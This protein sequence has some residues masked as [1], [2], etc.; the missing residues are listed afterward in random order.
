M[1]RK[2]G[3]EK[4]N[5]FVNIS[6]LI[7]V[8]SIWLV[9]RQ[10]LDHTNIYMIVRYTALT[11]ATAGDTAPSFTPFIGIALPGCI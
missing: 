7:I 3:L 10:K 1:K 8:P 9:E 4:D 2:V 6:F 5:V 11:K